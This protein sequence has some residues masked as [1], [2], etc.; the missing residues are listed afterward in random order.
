MFCESCIVVYLCNMNQQDALISF[1]FLRQI[2]STCFEHVDCSSSAGAIVNTQ[3]L[4]YVT[5]VCLLATSSQLK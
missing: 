1:S 4:V 2:I 3:Q 5:R